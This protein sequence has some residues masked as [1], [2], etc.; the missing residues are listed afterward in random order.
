MAVQWTQHG[1]L[2][3]RVPSTEIDSCTPGPVL[4]KFGC[5]VA[6]NRHQEV[7]AVEFA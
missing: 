4:E 7:H 3:S 1:T 2:V 5:A 6:E